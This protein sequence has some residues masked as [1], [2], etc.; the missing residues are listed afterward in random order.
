[1]GKLYLVGI[2]KHWEYRKEYSDFIIKTKVK[3]VFIEE[4]SNGWQESLQKD[5]YYEL[6]ESNIKLI[7][8]YPLTPVNFDNFGISMLELNYAKN[9]KKNI[10]NKDYCFTVGGMHLA[11]KDM[12]SSLEFALKAIDCNAELIPNN[13]LKEFPKNYEKKINYRK[14]IISKLIQEQHV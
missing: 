11:P 4:T 12:E 8:I 7:P 13:F 6:I 10:E 14:K 3:D 5:M 2:A 9:I 1:M